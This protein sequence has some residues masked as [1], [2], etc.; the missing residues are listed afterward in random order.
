MN[1]T[2]IIIN[3][4]LNIIIWIKNKIVFFNINTIILEFD[5]NKGSI[6]LTVMFIFIFYFYYED[7]F[8]S[9]VSSSNSIIY[10]DHKLN[11]DDT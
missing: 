4:Y 3:K 7:T 9:N 8:C 5:G 1:Q 6:G 2:M 11:T 10:I